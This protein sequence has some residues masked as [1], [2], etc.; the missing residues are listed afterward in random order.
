MIE[1]K[2]Y[3][4]LIKTND[5]YRK[6]F[7]IN[8]ADYKQYVYVNFVTRD[9]KCYLH[10]GSYADPTI[11]N[12]DTDVSDPV[13]RKRRDEFKAIMMI[14]C[15][16]DEYQPYFDEGYEYIQSHPDEDIVM[17]QWVQEIEKE[18]AEHENDEPDD[19]PSI[20]VNINDNND[21]E[22]YILPFSMNEDA[23]KQLYNACS[24]VLIKHDNWIEENKGY[25]YEHMLTEYKNSWFYVN[26]DDV[27]INSHNANNSTNDDSN[28]H[29]D[30]TDNDSNAENNVRAILTIGFM[31]DKLIMNVRF[32]MVG[33]RILN[34]PSDVSMMM[35]FVKPEL[36][37]SESIDNPSASITDNNENNI[38]DEV[39]KS[40][41]EQVESRLEG[42]ITMLMNTVDNI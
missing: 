29:Q 4:I 41:C 30:N 34:Q 23:Y 31:S 17:A 40:L 18:Q 15:L 14:I 19:I 1:N 33:G 27:N 11:Y 25:G 3:K 20:N 22:Y 6:S 28:T 21:T 9:I 37:L 7:G 42:F 38:D 12:K 10:D 36:S 26:N 13:V 32:I 2:T 5:N 16:A 24:S 39:M 8:D 35:P